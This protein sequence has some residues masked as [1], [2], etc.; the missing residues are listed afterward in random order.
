MLSIMRFVYMFAWWSMS[1]NSATWI[2]HLNLFTLFYRFKSVCVCVCVCLQ[3]LLFEP[4]QQDAD[5]I[6]TK[7]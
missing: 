2:K 3:L 6:V 7:R 1:W 4:Q 5:A